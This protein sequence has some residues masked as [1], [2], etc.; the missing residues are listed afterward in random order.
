MNAGDTYTFTRVLDQIGRAIVAGEMPAG[1]AG[2]IEDL[3]QR[4][5]ASRSVVREVTRVLGTLG[6]MSAG[7]RVGLTVLEA[8]HWNVL[9]PLV[10]RWRLDGEGRRAQLDELRA[11]RRAIEPAAAAAAAEPGASA[12]AAGIV[13]AAE[14]MRAATE[15]GD[16]RAFLVADRDFH[17]MILAASGNRMFAKLRT[18]VEENLRDRTL[19]EL[20]DQEPDATDVALHVQVAEAVARGDAAVARELMAQ[21]IERTGA[22][23]AGGRDQTVL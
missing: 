13:D 11:L 18:V 2:T 12:Q 16:T 22:V 6:M 17:A 7:R 14:R 10:I 20:A 15:A 23:G 21:I 19:R 8:E 4:V 3:V 1:P 5:G 9:D